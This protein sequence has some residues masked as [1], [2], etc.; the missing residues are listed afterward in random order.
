MMQTNLLDL[1]T[2]PGED[3]YKLPGETKIE[4]MNRFIKLVKNTD[5]IGNTDWNDYVKI[6]N[7]TP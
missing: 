5:D 2:I 1:I 7:E 3:K 4:M 6:I